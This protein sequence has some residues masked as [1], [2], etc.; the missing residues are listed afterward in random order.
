MEKPMNFEQEMQQKVKEIEEVLAYYSPKEEG[1]QRQIME[2]MNYSL[3]AGGKRLRPLLMKE[4]F[5]LFDG[6][7]KEILAPFMAALEMIHTYSLVHDDLPAM[8]NDEYRRGRKTTHVVYGKL[9][10]FSRGMA[11]LIML[12][13]RPQRLLMRR[14]TV[15]LTN[16]IYTEESRRHYRYWHEKPVSLG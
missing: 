11:C 9:W 12:L 4:T 5:E 3:M 1:F 16:L 2:A 7:H 6:Q 8:D 10:A 13:R 14:S 15:L